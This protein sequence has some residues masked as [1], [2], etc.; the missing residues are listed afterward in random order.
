MMSLLYLL[1]LLFLHGILLLVIVG[2]NKQGVILLGVL[3]KELSGATGKRLVRGILG[4][5]FKAR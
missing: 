4:S 5:L 1:H 3:L 2:T